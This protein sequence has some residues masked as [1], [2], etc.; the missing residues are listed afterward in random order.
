MPNKLKIIGANNCFHVLKVKSAKYF[1]K[2]KPDLFWTPKFVQ[3]CRKIIL[4]CLQFICL[5]Q[6]HHWFVCNLHLFVC[7]I[8][9]RFVCNIKQR[10]C[11]EIFNTFGVTAYVAMN[12]I[13]SRE[14]TLNIYSLWRYWWYSIVINSCHTPLPAWSV[15]QITNRQKFVALSRLVEGLN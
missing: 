11:F 3:K 12:P 15:G 6:Y 7:N 9:Y 5:Q 4:R 13:L 10:F 1:I 8:L 2:R 14:N